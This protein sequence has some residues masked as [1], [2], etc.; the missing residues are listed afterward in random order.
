MIFGAAPDPDGSEQRYRAAESAMWAHHGMS[1][2]ERWIEADALGIRVHAKE[3]GEGRPVVFIHGTPT[4]GGVFVPLVG[5]LSGVRAIVVDRPGC[6]LSDPLDFDDFTP[7]RMR[8]VIDGW[9][10]AVVKAVSDEPV[11]L[12]AS[13]AGGLVALVL[14]SRHPEL[15]R[16]VALLGAPAVEGMNLP[17]SMRLGTFAPVAR[18][19]ARHRV[20][21]RDLRRSFKSMGHGDLVRN[22]GLST[23][24]LEWRYA[25]SRDTTT[26]AHEMQLMRLAATWRGPRPGWV[27][28][29][30][31]IESLA[32]PSLWVAGE[33]DPFATPERIGEWASHARGSTVRVMPDSGHQPWIDHPADHARILED[34]WA[35]IG[36][37][38]ASEGDTE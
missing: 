5:Q 27:A 32:A 23:A 10:P 7:D 31:E 30:A 17:G 1:P 4:A 19:V 36:A 9:A 24:D 2:T 11:D 35:S 12:V 8:E 37:G 34:W 13:S 38:R 20:N 25:L 28:S 15:I 29:T 14:A 16:S 18:A 21:E 26:Y 6:A 22:G 33:H 3:H